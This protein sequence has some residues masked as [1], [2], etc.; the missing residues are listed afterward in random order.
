VLVA[1]LVAV[2]HEALVA[3]PPAEQAA[4][5]AADP[6]RALRVLVDALDG[7]GRQAV[8]RAEHVPLR[9]FAFQ[10][11]ALDAVL[12][13]HPEHLVAVQQQGLRAA[14][15]AGLHGEM[16]HVAR[17]GFQHVDAGR[18]GDPQPALL[19]ARQRVDL[20]VS[21]AAGVAPLMVVDDELAARRV[22]MLQ[23]VGRAQPQA[24]VAIVDDG[25]DVAIAAAALFRLLRQVVGE[26]LRLGVEQVEAAV[27]AHPHAAARVHVQHAD[28]VLRQAARVAHDVAVNRDLVAVEAAQAR[29]AAEPH[30][31]LAV[32]RDRQYRL[33][34]E[35]LLHV[36]LL[37]TQGARRRR[38]RRDGERA[39]QQQCGQAGDQ[40]TF[41][42]G[43]GS[44]IG[45]NGHCTIGKAQDPKKARTSARRAWVSRWP[46]RISS[47]V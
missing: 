47:W 6:H 39:S 43:H 45:K 36:Q 12:R 33:L 28:P 23:A 37:E 13:A 34:R 4:G 8:R 1:L 35:A 15:A 22:E 9:V 20:V 32:L 5:L 26:R 2:L 11:P 14:R 10:R 30:E 42:S 17:A 41:F 16:G 40:A 29:L 31:A 19:V 44:G 18:R 7:A 46:R 25:L 21:Q 3:R 24:V 27:R 38:Q